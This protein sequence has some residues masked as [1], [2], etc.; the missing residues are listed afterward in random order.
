MP[1]TALNSAASRRSP[2]EPWVLT[3]LDAEPVIVK[4][5]PLGSAGVRGDQ[6]ALAVM[7]S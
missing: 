5:T 6:P 3:C 7:G 4:D 1:V 2:S